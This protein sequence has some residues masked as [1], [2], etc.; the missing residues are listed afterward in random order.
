MPPL[1]R[2]VAQMTID[3][4]APGASPSPLPSRELLS[5]VL[6]GGGLWLTLTFMA[7][8]LLIFTPLSRLLCTFWRRSL[9]FAT[10]LR[11]ATYNVPAVVGKLPLLFQMLDLYRVQVVALQEVSIYLPTRQRFRNVCRQHGFNVV[12]GGLDEAGVTK[13]ALLSSLPITEFVCDSACPDRIACGVAE[14]RFGAG[15]ETTYSK[16]LVSSVYAHA[17]DEVAREIF[18]KECLQSFSL[19]STRWVALGDFN[20][21][22][23][24]P[25]LAPTLAS[26]AVH[27]LDHVFLSSL[28]P[29][30]VMATDA[31]TSGL[32][33]LLLLL[34]RGSSLLTWTSVFRTTT[35]WLMALKLATSVFP[36][37]LV[38]AGKNPESFPSQTGLREKDGFLDPGFF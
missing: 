12:F 32:L 8:L 2:S 30:V 20:L 15:S 3:A 7:F 35:W 1:G 31:L 24:D 34:Y 5:S 14:L 25:S 17:C 28:R 33:I 16:L 4:A 9:A 21:E 11:C 38:F 37:H 10:E 23:E 27:C 22:V 29:R 36:G 6:Q 18:L 19:L 26:G 13:V